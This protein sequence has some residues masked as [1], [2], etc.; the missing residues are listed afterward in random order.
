MLFYQ[1][2]VCKYTPCHTEGFLVS[3]TLTHTSHFTKNVEV[4]NQLN[5]Q[6]VHSH[7]CTYS[8]SVAWIYSYN[9]LSDHKGMGTVFQ[10][11][12]QVTNNK[13]ALQV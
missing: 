2:R 12:F 11:S 9:V 13:A 7:V 6:V 4:Q 10:I 5:N 3:V 1:V 8:K